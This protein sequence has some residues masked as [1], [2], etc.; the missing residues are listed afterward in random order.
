MGKMISMPSSPLWRG[1]TDVDVGSLRLGKELGKGG[2]GRVVQVMDHEPPLV[3]KEYFVPG[4]DGAAL[5]NLVDMPATLTPA[6]QDR[7]HRQMAWPLAR[8]L[9][10]GGLSGFLM[11]EIPGRFLGRNSAGSS[12]LRELQ[13][14]L[15]EPSLLWGDISPPDIAGRIEVARHFTALMQ[16]LHDNALIVGDVSMKNVL[17]AS[18]EPAE[19]FLIDCDSIHRVGTRPVLQA[20]DT[21]DWHDPRQPPHGSSLDSDRYKLALAVGRVLS[22]D[23]SLRPGQDLRLLPGIPDR[24]AETVRAQWRQAAGSYGA[25]PDAWHWQRALS[26][27]SEIPLPAPPPVRTRPQ[28]PEADVIQPR[29]TRGSIPLRP[30][31]PGSGRPSRP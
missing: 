9:R 27:R 24:I 22:R 16:F 7:L 3:F 13:Y 28:I 25:R 20:A 17:W 29:T 11:R 15:Y 19:I 18:G 5:K 23:A 2:Q 21:P 26:D 4:A 8:V 14:L 12:R 30:P 1:G 31:S 6:D 10:Q